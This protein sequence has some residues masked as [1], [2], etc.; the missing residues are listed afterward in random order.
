M[1]SRRVFPIL[2]A[3]AAT[4]VIR[5][6]APPAG[7]ASTPPSCCCGGECTCATARDDDD[8]LALERF[9]DMRD[10]QLD[11]IQ[12]AIAR[13]R[14]MPPEER[15]A[16]HARLHAFRQLPTGQ[17]ERLRAGWRDERDQADWQQMIR[18]LSAPQRDAIQAELQSLAPAERAARKHQLLEAWRT[19]PAPQ[20]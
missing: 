16:L 13:V 2:L 11:R 15:A 8:F 19:P 18:S 5:A 4:G 1:N 20:P 3:L 12:R 6:D 10:E 17:R 7:T 9:L 14:A